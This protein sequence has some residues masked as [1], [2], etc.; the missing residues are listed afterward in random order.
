[1]SDDDGARTTTKGGSVSFSIPYTAIVEGRRGRDKKKYGNLDGLIGSLKSVGS[2]HPIVLGKRPDGQYDLIAGG[3]RYRAMGQ[4]QVKELWHH[5]V[6]DPEKLGFV[7]KEEVPEHIL[8]E[9]E[10]DENLHRLD[11]DWI[12]NVLMVADVHEMKKASSHKWGYRQTAELLGDGYGLSNVTYAIN[13]AKLIRANDKDI[14]ACKHMREAIAVM[15]KRKEDAALAELNR[16]MLEKTGGPK[17]ATSGSVLVDLTV[18]GVGTSSFLDTLTMTLGPKKPLP[19]LE[20]T[21]PVLEMPGTVK[22]EPVHVP[23]SSMFLLGDSLRTIMPSMPDSSFDHIVTDIPYGIDMDNLTLKGQADVAAQHEVVPNVNDMPIFLEQSFRLVKSGGFCVFFMDAEHF[24][25]LLNTAK[26]I[27][28][29]TQDWMLIWVK[30]HNCKNQ[31][32]AFNYTKTYETA[33]VL[34]KDEKTVLRKSGPNSVWIGDGAAERKL[35]NNPFAKPFLLWKELIFD[36]IAFT[37]QTVYDPY[38]GELSSCKAALNC[39]LLPYGSEISPVH[40]NRGL[41][42]MK[43]AYSVI[44]NS[45]CTF[46]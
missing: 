14:L 46:A 9:A 10:L 18:P 30:T 39:G 28:W 20:K 17:A 19:T 2:I 35:Y 41:E 43:A 12:D 33:M 6:L 25:F 27:G 7:F 34:R 26:A 24:T 32:P 23:L 31:A 13:L 11:V 29:K 16:R 4:M 5:S 1:M 8:R 37:G 44:H 15:T 42:H 22:P 21:G 3:R 36:N 45:N 40:L 38:A